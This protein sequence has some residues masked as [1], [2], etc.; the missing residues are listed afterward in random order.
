MEPLSSLKDRKKNTVTR[1]SRNS[2]IFK[3]IIQAIQEKK[4]EHIISLDLRKVAESATDFFIICQANNTTQLKAISDFVE[5]EVKL[6]CAER[7][8]KTEGKQGGQWLL[9]DYINVV[10]HIM[11]PESRNFYQI[12]EMWNDSDAKGHDE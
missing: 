2:K 6:K 3:T 12:E 10:V 7:P 11:H 4:G 5:Y 9:I 8:Y 1:L